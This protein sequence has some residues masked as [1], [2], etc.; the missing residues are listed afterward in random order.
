[1]MIGW[2][3][4][5]MAFKKNIIDKITAIE[6][7]SIDYLWTKSI[8]IQDQASIVLFEKGQKEI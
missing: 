7:I 3:P 2:K 1:M 5:I 8:V 6:S 4:K